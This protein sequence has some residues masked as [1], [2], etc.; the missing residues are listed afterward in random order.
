MAQ[1]D[2]KPSGP[3]L[4]Q[5]HPVGDLAEGGMLTGHVGDDEVLLV[6]H[7]GKVSAIGAHCTHYHGPL[8]DG[9]VVGNTIR[10]PW[11]H[12]CFDLATGEALAAPALSPLTCWRVEER[13]GK[14]IVGAKIEQPPAEKDSARHPSASSSSAAARPALPQPRCCAGAALP[15][16]SR[17]SATTTPHRSTAPIC[18]RTISPAARRRTGCRCAATTGTPTTTSTLK[19][20]TEVTALDPKAKELTLGDGS[21]LKFDKLLLATGAEPVKLPIPGADQKH[22]HT[23]ALA[24]RQPRHHRAGEVRQA[25]GRDRRELHRPRGGGRVARARHRGARGRAGKAPARTRVR[26]AARRFHPRAARGARRQI[27]SRGQRHGDRRQQRHAQE[28]RHARRRPGGHRR[29]RAAAPGARRKGRTRRSTKASASTNTWRPARRASTP[30][31]TSRAG[32]TRIPASASASS[33]GW[34]PSGRARPRRST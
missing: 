25:R 22:V 32:P 11:H 21:K 7:G 28:R 1:D 2:K 31:A 15:A 4:D 9:L 20:K 19:L 6:R 10:C 24:R 14:I 5:G 26:A 29:R 13:G 16:A 3:D 12:A 27:P 30:P 18:R 33:T 17:C 23:L 8:A 34:W